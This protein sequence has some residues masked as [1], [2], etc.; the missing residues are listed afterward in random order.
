MDGEE[1]AAGGRLVPSLKRPPSQAHDRTAHS[2]ASRRGAARAV[3]LRPPIIDSDFTEEYCMSSQQG[4]ATVLV[5]YHSS[6]GHTKRMAE[7]VADG[8][9]SVPDTKVVMRSVDEVQRADFKDCDALIVARP[10]SSGR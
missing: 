2:E 8:V 4:S 3:S 5:V 10:C 9:R 6:Q 7:A 1:Q